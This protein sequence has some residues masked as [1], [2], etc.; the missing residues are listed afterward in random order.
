MIR[1]AALLLTSAFALAQTPCENLKSLSLPTVT[2][3]VA[4]PVAAGPFRQPGATP[5]AGAQKGAAKQQA[6]GGAPQ[7]QP[8][9]LPAYCRVAATLAPSPDSDI[10]M[11]LWLPSSDWN[12]K[13]EAVGG[14]GWA[15][16]I[17]FPAMA[18]ALQER[19]ATAST[20]TGHVGG[21][22]DF[23]LGHPEKIV[24]FGYR[25]IH[26]MTLKSKDIM[27]A[28][29]GRAPRLS[30]FN[31]CSTGG[32]Q[33]LMEVQR[34]PEDFDG[35]IAGAPAN[36]H[37]H[38]HAASVERNIELMK[39]PDHVLSPDK[40]E[41]LAKSV[42]AACDALDGV[43]DGILANPR[44]CTFD[45]AAL[46]CKN[47][48]S[49]TCLTAPQ[50]EG[51]KVAY[52]DVKTSKGE[53]VWTGFERGSEAA[54]TLL[55]TQQTTIGPGALD[56]I[57]IL[58]Y[59][60]RSWDWHNFNLDRDVAFADE[61]AGYIN[62]SIT[63]LSA[64]KNH[65]GKLILY[66][67]WSDPGISPGNTVNYYSAVLGKMGQKQDNWMR[68]FMVPGMLHCRG[69]PGPDQF[70][71]LGA[72]ERWRESNTAPEQII[73]SHVSNNRVDMTRPLCPYPQVAV[74]KG[75]GSTNDA[76]NF[77]CKAQ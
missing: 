51:V 42:L 74:Y 59:Q 52:R 67:G 69:G 29:Y 16:N 9:M 43:K 35:V 5:A 33:A 66:H 2:I 30:F 70:S 17:S 44:K 23:A 61:K 41:F 1:A 75:S 50:V 27:R 68:L 60:D 32:R 38:L 49:D 20:D 58:G 6:K 22:A 7:Q 57:R 46:L 48:D 10:K 3:T 21:N 47:G 25:A 53:I 63:D 76:S 19:Y 13:F 56:S 39:I 45:P 73:A 4:E 11:E 72:I 34:Y 12:G 15:G 14:G 31:G 36:A 64:F 18:T 28:Y 62:A 40:Q 55:R 77:A 54:W 71:A 65:G 24:D 26:E 37:I 8:T